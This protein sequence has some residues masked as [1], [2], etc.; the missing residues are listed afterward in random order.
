MIYA[1]LCAGLP[2]VLETTAANLP[3]LP[4]RGIGVVQPD[5][6]DRALF[7]YADMFG[8]TVYASAV[9]DL[10]AAIRPGTA[11]TGRLT[12]RDLEANA[13][14]LVESR[15]LSTGL[16]DDVRQMN[17]VEQVLAVPLEDGG[18]ATLIAGIGDGRALSKEERGHLESVAAAAGRLLSPQETPEEELERLRRLEAVERLLPAFFN[19]LDVRDIFDQV[20]AIAN[21]VLPHDFASVGTFN[22][23]LSEV[24]LYAR[25][26]TIP[27]EPYTGPMPYAPAQ[28]RA[29]LC[30]YVADLDKHP[31]DRVLDAMARAGGRASVR[32]VL[33]F[34]DQPLGGLNFTSLTPSRYTALDLTIARRVADYVALGISHH[35]MA[36][37]GRRAAALEER[38][39]RLETRVRLLTDELDARTG[40]RHTTGESKPW[41]AVLT[42]ATKVAATDT[43]VLLLGESGTGKEVVARFLHRASRRSGGPFI[44]MNC[45]ALPE[46]LLEAELFG[47]E[48]GA[49]TGATQSKPGQLEQAS[50]GTLFLDEVGE[51]S[52]SAQAKFLR[53]LQEREFQRLGGTRVLRTD[54]RI[55]AATNLDL[56]RAMTQGRFREDLFYR[57]NVFAI[58]LPPLRDRREDIPILTDAFLAEFSSRFGRPPAGISREALRLLTAYHWPGNVRELRNSLERASILCEGGLITPEH[59]TFRTPSRG[60][61]AAAPAT[62]ATAT[63]EAAGDIASVEKSMIEQA[64]KHAKFNKSQAARKLG[65]TRQQLYVRMRRYGLE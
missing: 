17:R 31:V 41:K 2:S 11:G 55:V 27:I 61:A 49:Y 48:R 9:A 54:A 23:R 59:L 39:S 37:E 26:H 32:V 50:G 10:P 53:V 1:A 15:L 43:T 56:E 20:S 4:L 60:Q 52:P 63:A 5:G 51:M 46:Q 40:Y 12:V 36:E 24:T 28:T 21:D 58:Q 16:S 65:L 6:A 19:V 35:R 45:A 18:G 30:R 13:H 47:Y 3:D 42:Q 44:A 7:T 29:W 64:L 57:L 22:D 33:K 14:G 25:S 62:V 34:G 8:A 38:N